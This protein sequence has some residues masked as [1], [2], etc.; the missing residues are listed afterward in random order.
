MVA[1]RRATDACR[2]PLAARNEL[3]G[4]LDAY[5]AKANALGLLEEPRLCA[6]YDQAHTSLYTA[7]TDLAA[8]IG[9]VEQYQQ[10]LSHTPRTG[11]R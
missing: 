4:R 10:A 3:R 9:L 11:E 6:L 7:P 2:A 1:T 8:A 5:R